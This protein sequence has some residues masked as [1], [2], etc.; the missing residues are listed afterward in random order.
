MSGKAFA[1]VVFSWAVLIFLDF[2]A[3]GVMYGRT[4]L[5]TVLSLQVFRMQ[6][7][8]FVSVPVPQMEWLGSV[9]A[10][11][12]WNFSFYT[13]VGEWARFF[14][15]LSMMGLLWWGLITNVFP[16]LISGVRAIISLIDAFNP[17]T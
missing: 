12:T 7:V 8:L 10:L 17:L 16:T 14:L 4:N 6:D 1:W 13:G 5:E 9:W 15:G 3:S 2:L 11:A